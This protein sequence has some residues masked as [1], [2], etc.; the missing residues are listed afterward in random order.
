MC[1][2]FDCDSTLSTL[3]GIDELAARLNLESK[4]A[5]LTAAAMDGRIAIEAVYARRM[6]LIKPDRESLMWL[7]QR[8]IAT[9]VPGAHEAFAIL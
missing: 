9:L 4:I 7:G 1:V 2:C 6:A 3:E 5:P 8:Y